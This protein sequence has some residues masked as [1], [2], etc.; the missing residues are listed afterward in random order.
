MKQSTLRTILKKTN[1]NHRTIQILKKKII[2]IKQLDRL[3][4]QMI[5]DDFQSFFVF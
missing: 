2:I 3:L 4:F 1:K 5:V